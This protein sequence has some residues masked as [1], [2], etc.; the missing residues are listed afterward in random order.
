MLK[1]GGLPWKRADYVMKKR[2]AQCATYFFG[3]L[4]K[5]GTKIGRLQKFIKCGSVGL[6]FWPLATA[7]LQPYS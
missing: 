6:N 3:L 1:K 2:V 7:L 4:R 5:F